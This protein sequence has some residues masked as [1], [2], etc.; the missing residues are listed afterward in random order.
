MKIV[1]C[2][3]C[4]GRAQHV[5]RTLPRNL[6]DNADYADFKILLLDYNSDDHLLE[7]VR[8]H[9]A[10]DLASGRLVVYSY[11]EPGPFRMSH[12]KNLAHRLAIEEG[13]DVL[14]NMDADNWAA[15][16]FATWIAEQFRGGCALLW[17]KATSVGGR[18]RPDRGP[19]L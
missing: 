11:R 1:F 13:A 4:K 6:S 10:R 2:T 5:E 18:G 9:H 8:A 15:P 16:G 7:Y 3:T 17:T 14:V 19:W 12:A